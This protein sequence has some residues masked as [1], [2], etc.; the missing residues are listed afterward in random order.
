[1]PND[2]DK[3]ATMK[4]YFAC[5]DAADFVTSA[6]MFADDAVYLRPPYVPGQAAFASSGTERIEGLAAISEFWENRG[7]RNTHHVIKIE[8]ISGS[9]WFAEGEVSVDDS[10]TRMFLTHV[11]F[12]DKGRIQRFVAL[13]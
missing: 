13:R 4:Q 3:S 1:M 2:T 11:T 7:K 10:E 9:E 6:G 8:S 12:N 5:M